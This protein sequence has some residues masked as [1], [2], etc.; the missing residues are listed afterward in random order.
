MLSFS[1]F[2]KVMLCLSSMWLEVDRNKAPCMMVFHLFGGCCPEP[3]GGVSALCGITKGWWY[4]REMFFRG[5]FSKKIGTLKFTHNIRTELEKKMQHHRGRFWVVFFS[6]LVCLLFQPHPQH[7]QSHRPVPVEL[8]KRD[9]QR[10]VCRTQCRHR[11][12][13]MCWEKKY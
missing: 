12:K 5:H 7:V 6:D 8:P 4:F 2:L 1:F 13:L 11:C 9:G 10:D 3:G